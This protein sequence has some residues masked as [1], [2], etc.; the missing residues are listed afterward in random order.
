MR[1]AAELR[2]IGGTPGM[3]HPYQD[4]PGNGR[5]DRWAGLT[6]AEQDGR[7]NRQPR[8]R[9]ELDRADF[10]ESSHCL[11]RVGVS[12]KFPSWRTFLREPGLAET[13][14]N[15]SDQPFNRSSPNDVFVNQAIRSQ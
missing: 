2:A 3:F 10:S 5:R 1:S 13:S 8:E 4:N 9:S 6:G 12:S 7:A 11:F 14:H 15:A